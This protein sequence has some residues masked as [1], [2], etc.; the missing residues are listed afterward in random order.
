MVKYHFTS[1]NQEKL[2]VEY[3]KSG[4]FNKATYSIQGNKLLVFK[5]LEGSLIL[6][7]LSRQEFN[8]LHFGQVTRV[9]H[10][11]RSID[12]EEGP[13]FDLASF[14]L[15]YACKQ[16]EESRK[17][18]DKIGHID[19]MVAR[20]IKNARYNTPHRLKELAASPET[21][22]HI[23]STQEENIEQLAEVWFPTYLSTL[24]EQLE[25]KLLALQKNFE[26]KVRDY[27]HPEGDSKKASKK[28]HSSDI[29]GSISEIY[30]SFQQALSFMSQHPNFD[31]QSA[32]NYWQNLD[33]LAEKLNGFEFL[34]Y[35]PEFISHLSRH[36]P[37][38]STP[39]SIFTKHCFQN[40][41]QVIDWAFS[42]LKK[43]D[44]KSFYQGQIL[45]YTAKM[46]NTV[47]LDAVILVSELPDNTE[48]KK[49][50]RD[51]LHE[52]NV[53]YGIE[54]RPTNLITIVAGP[55]PE[56]DYHGFLSIFPGKNYP[57]IEEAP[58]VWEELAF[59]A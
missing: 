59:I 55:I 57:P 58:E 23:I 54:K 51:G 12:A 45:H 20:Y 35:D 39:G 29:L 1:S 46:P 50:K 31:T 13:R 17:R 21:L 22:N 42:I 41:I 32:S 38:T 53:A 2:I 3:F 15:E 48:I 52:I 7:D 47:G 16:L 4:S 26:K 40:P 30:K 9:P 19:D 37:G 24:T 25:S 11:E 8:K 56:K 43:P 5:N 18:R 14:D 28:I 36:F 6:E 33:S 27:V 10:L 34:K 44:S 49:E